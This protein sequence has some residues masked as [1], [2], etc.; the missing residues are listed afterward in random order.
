MTNNKCR[1]GFV[2]ILGPANSG[3]STLI[4]RLIGKKISIVSNKVQT[5]RFSV[6]GVLNLNIDGKEK[7][8][9]QI[10]F[11]DTPGIFKPKRDLDKLI[12]NDAM[13]N[14]KDSDHNLLISI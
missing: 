12:L 2:S 4:N 13:N 9:S 10:I 1:S 11:V 6:R 14:I 8:K 3:K 5:T 7:E